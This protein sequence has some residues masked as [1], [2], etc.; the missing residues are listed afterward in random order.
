MTSSGAKAR[1]ERG[2]DV[3]LCSFHEVRV[4]LFPLSPSLFLT[5]LFLSADRLFHILTRPGHPPS[6]HQNLGELDQ[7]QLLPTGIHTLEDVKAYGEEHGI[8]PYFAVR[9]MVRTFSYLSLFPPSSFS[10]FPLLHS[11]TNPFFLDSTRLDSN[12]SCMPRSS[13]TPSTTSS[14]PKSQSKS[15]STCQ[16][17]QSSSL[18]KRTTSV[19]CP[20]PSP[21]FP[22][23]LR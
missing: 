15:R 4:F 8:C 13:S 23:P 6:S 3:E 10:L 20:L 19:R 18:T 1:L 16:R 22:I 12:S 2:E 5:P 11:L 17:T 9:R 21:F 7:D 14:T